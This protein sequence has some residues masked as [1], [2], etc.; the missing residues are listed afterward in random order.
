MSP[1][2]ML[3]LTSATIKKCWFPPTTKSK[4]NK[5]KNINLN[6][7]LA[8]THPPSKWWIPSSVVI[9]IH[10]F[11]GKLHTHQKVLI[12]NNSKGVKRNK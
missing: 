9:I 4:K 6:I 7:S 3:Y 5:N 10:V 11:I 2:P 12:H 8:I 1:S